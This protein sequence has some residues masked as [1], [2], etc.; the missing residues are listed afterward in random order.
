MN[1]I[2][3]LNWNSAEETIS[4]IES[5][6]L[7]E[8][9]E[10]N[11]I[12][13]C[14]NNS[15][16]DSYRKILNYLISNFND[17]FLELMEDEIYSSSFNHKFYLIKNKKNYGYAGGNNVG[18]KFALNSRDM[19]YVWVLNNDTVVDNN[20]IQELVKKCDLDKEIGVCGARLVDFYNRKKV[21]S[22]GA[23]INTW[24]CVT[25]AIG[26]NFEKDDVINEKE[27]ETILDFVVGA[28][29][30]FS[31]NFL[32]K[33]GLLCE[34]YFLYYEEIDICNRAR[35]YGFK[36]GVASKSIVYH[37][38]GAST[39]GDISEVADYYMVRNRIL[40]ARKFYKN[41]VVFVKLSLFIIIINRFRRGQFNRAFKYFKFLKI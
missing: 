15:K 11:R 34:D 21:Q 5:L 12:I 26:N 4:C 35:E 18:I 24:F 22:L 38:E 29:L 25:R 23:K 32:E 28:S 37:M 31:R 9:N 14:D 33:V 1:Y 41:K 10:N 17:D 2:V 13:I 7:V 16:N 40:I 30:F 27:I 3:V 39:V 6:V 36:V 20:A 19:K 8:G